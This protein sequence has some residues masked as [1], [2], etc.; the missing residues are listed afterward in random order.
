MLYKGTCSKMFCIFLKDNYQLLVD[1]PTVI[2]FL[3][4]K[5]ENEKQ[6]AQF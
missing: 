6:T 2:G 1:N 5:S 4:T 3:Q